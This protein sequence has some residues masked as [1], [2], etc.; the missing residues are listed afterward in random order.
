M[1]EIISSFLSFDNYT[2]RE[3]IFNHDN[4]F[5]NDGEQIQLEYNFGADS[6]INE[7]KTNAKITL[8]CEI[9]NENLYLNDQSPF[10]I[11]VKL[12]GFF[13][14]STDIEI[15]EFE[16]NGIAILL[17]YLRAFVTSFTSQ[18]GIPVVIIPPINVYNMLNNNEE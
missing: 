13:S 7:D 16:L 1:S 17:P 11:R 14:C 2:I 5:E 6:A 15:N 8:V 3:F 9:F 10:Y 18:A 4:K 12:D